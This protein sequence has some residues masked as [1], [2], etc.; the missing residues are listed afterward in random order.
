VHKHQ[1]VVTRGGFPPGEGD[2]TPA[3]RARQ[4]FGQLVAVTVLL[5]ALLAWA[6]HRCDT[7]SRSGR[8][9]FAAL[10][11]TLVRLVV[12]VSATAL[13]R[14]GQYQ[15][16]FGWIVLRILVAASEAWLAVLLV[17]V[18]LLWLRRRRGDAC[19]G[20]GAP[21]G[22]AASASVARFEN[23]GRIDAAYLATLSA[24]AVPA[25]ASCRARSAARSSRA[26]PAPP[27][28]RRSTP[29]STA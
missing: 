7:A 1:P 9:A 21:R 13:G 5:V 6:G 22:L 29:R 17:A 14:M 10:G 26:W 27:P 4:G 20:P 15:E 16:A 25:V 12:A 19:H 11:G 18:S 23:T 28:A 3:G 2:A 8:A 24:A